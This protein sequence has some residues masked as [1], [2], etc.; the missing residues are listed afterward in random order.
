[1]LQ[2]ESRCLSPFPSTCPPLPTALV[3]PE[4][5][6]L[7]SPELLS[8]AESLLLVVDLQER[9]LPVIHDHAAVTSACV[10]LLRGAAIFG[11]PAVMTEQYPKGLGATVPEIAAAAASLD[12]A[13]LTRAEK[14]RFGAAEATGWPPAGERDDGR[15]QV[16][17]AGI[18]THVCI[19]QT[20]LDLISQGYRVYLAADASGSRRTFDRDVALQRLRDSGVTITTTESV[21]FEWCE[22]A[23]TD[24]FK[25]LRDLVKG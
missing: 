4:D 3:T 6:P 17:L 18:E 20:A 5:R 1:M 8:A 7:R 25:Q 12:P 9:L 24:R 22:E 11:V 14:L 21:L 10:R 16:V 23:G 2:P 19:L 13:N 15:H